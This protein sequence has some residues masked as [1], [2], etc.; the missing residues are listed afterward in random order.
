MVENQ[1]AKKLAKKT[2]GMEWL[3][4]KF[5]SLSKSKN[6]S[7]SKSL[8]QGVQTNLVPLD[9]NVTTL[10][11]KINEKLDENQQQKASQIIQE[12]TFRK[13]LDDM[14]ETA[15]AEYTGGHR[16]IDL[17]QFNTIEEIKKSVEDTIAKQQRFS[18]L[19]DCAMLVFVCIK[20]GEVGMD[21]TQA[22]S[23]LTVQPEV[24]YLK[25]VQDAVMA[26][27]PLAI[28]FDDNGTVTKFLSQFF[29]DP[30]HKIEKRLDNVLDSYVASKLK[31]Q[32]KSILVVLCIITGIAVGIGIQKGIEK[33]IKE[34]KKQLQSDG[35]STINTFDVR[36]GSLDRYEQFQK[37]GTDNTNVAN[38][39]QPAA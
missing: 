31:I 30:S 29:F 14:T 35:Y 21:V 19:I 16:D 36:T 8:N 26:A 37:C 2:N 24:K 10:I 23:T 12:E 7:K 11:D 20:A 27:I 33:R 5:G 3:V 22:F 1:D 38:G 28:I 15:N 34:K 18:L 6:R 13:V 4:K 25:A 9:N 32:W 17:T 39:C